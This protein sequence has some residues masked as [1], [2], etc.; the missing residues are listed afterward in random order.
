MNGLKIKPQQLWDLYNLPANKAHEL[1]I[2]LGF[3]FNQRVENLILYQAHGKGFILTEEGGIVTKVQ[4]KMTDR[5]IYYDCIEYAKETLAFETIFEE[6]EPSADVLR[7]DDA[8]CTLIAMAIH[9]NGNHPSFGINLLG[10]LPLPTPENRV[11]V[12]L[13]PPPLS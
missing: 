10:K 13:M 11:E 5:T 1:L 3:S 12:I 2:A 8:K 4:Y 6:F 7:L 9:T